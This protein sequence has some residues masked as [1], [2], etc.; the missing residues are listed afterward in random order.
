M[1]GRQKKDR[2][3]EKRESGITVII[4]VTAPDHLQ[5]CLLCGLFPALPWKGFTVE[6]PQ[7]VSLPEK[8]L[9]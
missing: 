3:N 7:L 2:Q 4:K 1:N 8:S 5:K 6:L 9:N